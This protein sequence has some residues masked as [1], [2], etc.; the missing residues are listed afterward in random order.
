MSIQSKD[1]TVSLQLQHDGK[2]IKQWRVKEKQ[3][4]HGVHNIVL[5]A[6]ADF[7]NLLLNEIVNNSHVFLNGVLTN[8]IKYLADYPLTD[9]SISE[10]LHYERRKCEDK[11]YKRTK[12]VFKL[13]SK[14]DGKILIK[15]DIISWRL[16][17]PLIIEKLNLEYLMACLS[18][19]GGAHSSLGEI[20]KY[21]SLRAG[22]IS[23]QQFKIALHVGDPVVIARC[24]IFMAHSLMQRGFLNRAAKIIKR[25]YE[26]A[27]QVS[28]ENS[29]VITC[30]LAAWCKYKYMK[31]ILKKDHAIRGR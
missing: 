2:F 15:K 12:I 18:T 19:L 22:E 24:K 30:C 6:D 4:I 3:N 20:S 11:K 23:M 16:Y 29:L 27:K 13:C 9:W 1:Q 31:S 25:E 7:I 5:T 17:H 10:L 28:Y 21:H 26:S 14:G 8:L